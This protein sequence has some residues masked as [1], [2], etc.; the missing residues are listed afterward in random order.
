MSGI[1]LVPVFPGG[2]SY[3]EV[4]EHYADWVKRSR[5]CCLSKAYHIY[6][7]QNLYIIVLRM[8]AG[9]LRT[10]INRAVCVIYLMTALKFNSFTFS[11]FPSCHSGILFIL[12]A[13]FASRKHTGTNMTTDEINILKSIEI[14]I[15]FPA[16]SLSLSDAFSQS[17]VSTRST[18]FSCNHPSRYYRMLLMEFAQCA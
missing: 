7:S 17:L 3:Y 9:G 14:Y 10:P 1:I 2:P 6:R 16:L 5:P 15:N 4:L 13:S 18:E 11:K 12:F 8:H